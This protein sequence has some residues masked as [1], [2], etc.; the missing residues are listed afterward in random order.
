[1]VWFCTKIRQFSHVN[2]ARRNDII[3]LSLEDIN[4]GLAMKGDMHM[5]QPGDRVVYSSHGVCDILF[6]EYR[7]IDRKQV[8]YYVLSPVERSEA[9]FFIPT[10]N[11][12]AVSKLRPLISPEGIDMILKEQGNVD[13]VWIVDEGIRKQKYRE[14]ISRGEPRDLVGMVH[15]LHLHRKSQR[16][17]GR[18][19]H[20]CD[21]NFLRDAE[22]LI[23]S[24]FSLV[25]GISHEAVK[26]YI[27]KVSNIKKCRE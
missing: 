23:Y 2:F 13:P 11:E 15:A 22:K 26:T 25:L 3:L 17:N 10:K 19:F 27:H 16:E 8:E 24:E 4:F 14:L 5:Y 1:M 20:L 21:E 9:R 12:L 18:K 7:T 6:L